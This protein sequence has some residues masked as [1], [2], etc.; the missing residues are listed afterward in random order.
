MCKECVR[1]PTQCF[2]RNKMFW[3]ENFCP[4]ISYRRVG[5]EKYYFTFLNVKVCLTVNAFLL[6]DK[7]R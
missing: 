7:T 1:S 3:T 4:K 2:L 5:N 6:T